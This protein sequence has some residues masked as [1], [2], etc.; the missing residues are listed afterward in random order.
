MQGKLEAKGSK[1]KSLVG[2]PG[3]SVTSL[4]DN[5]TKYS[6]GS[7]MDFKFL[8]NL[9]LYLA[10]SAGDGSL[11][12]LAAATD[13]AAKSGDFY[14]PTNHAFLSRVCVLQAVVQ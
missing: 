6:P 14:A 13:P 3:A 5:I 12:L 7:I 9:F 11:P 1:V 8:K 2:H 4:A 10:Q